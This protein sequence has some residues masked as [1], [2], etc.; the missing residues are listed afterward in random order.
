MRKE[1][2]LVFHRRGLRSFIAVDLCAECPRQDQKGC[3][4]FYSP[5]FYPTDLYFLRLRRPELIDHIKGLPRLT[6]LDASITV[7]SVPDGEGLFRCQFHTPQQGCLLPMS[8]R[9]S[10]CR[11]FVCPGIDWWNEERLSH[12][13]EYFEQLADYEIKLNNTLAL[14]L[15]KE[16]LSLRNPQDWDQA[17]KLIDDMINEALNQVESLGT[18][19]PRQEAARIVRSLAFGSEWPL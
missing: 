8:L 1:I 9:E 10:V 15:S 7:D 13:K 3:C 19:L 6:V 18:D 5:V 4:G 14:C 2:N 17:F 11:H 12:W 16:G